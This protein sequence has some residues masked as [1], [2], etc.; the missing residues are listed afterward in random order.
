MHES[1]YALKEE[2]RD[3]IINAAMKIFA[4]SP[5]RKASTDDIAAMAEIS[6][7]SLFY[8]FKNK[9]DLYC[10]LYQYSCTK[11]YNKIEQYK[12]MEETDFFE[13]NIKVVNAR[14]HTMMEYPFIFDFALR[15]YYETDTAVEKNIKVINQNILRM[16][17]SN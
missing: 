2:K 16:P 3:R 8:H 5:Y 1:F 6:K 12:A 13:R 7:G 11:I 9:P 4:Q 15:A 14:V 17:L 10:F